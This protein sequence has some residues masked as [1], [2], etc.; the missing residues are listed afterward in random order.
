MGHADGRALDLTV[1]RFAAQLRGDLVHTGRAGHA[2]R[3]TLREQ[4]AR[5]VHGAGA[6]APRSPPVDEVAGAAG[7]AE[8]EVVVVDEL[9]GGEAVVELDQVEVGRTDARLLVRLR[10]R[11]AGERV[12]VGLHL[13]ALGPRVG[14]EDRRTD[15]H[16]PAL[17]LERQRLELRV[18]H[19]H[20]RRRRHRWGST[21]AA[22]SGTRSR[23]SLISSSVNT[24]LYCASGF[25]AECAWF[26]SATLANW[27]KPTP[28]C[29]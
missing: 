22:C 18:G 29:S 24:L 28:S 21:S 15:L 26:F 8:P 25:N 13:R 1:A 20:D 16:G 5:H 2:D 12:D 14:R 23:A 27:S 11:V 19:E 17:L 3:V 10:R 6:V 7:L 4:P 9:G